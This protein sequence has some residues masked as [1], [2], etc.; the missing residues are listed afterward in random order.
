MACKRKYDGENVGVEGERIELEVAEKSVLLAVVSHFYGKSY[1]HI[2]RYYS[3]LPSKYGVCLPSVDWY[4]FLQ[5]LKDAKRP[6]NCMIGQMEVKVMKNGSLHL[7]S[8]KTDVDLFVKKPA[9][10]NLLKG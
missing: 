9:L 3:N 2:R 5:F 10:D 1:V 4:E 8:H 6:N 7:I